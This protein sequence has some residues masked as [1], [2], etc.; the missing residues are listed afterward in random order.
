MKGKEMK[1]FII[2]TLLSFIGGFWIYDKT[3]SDY[4][5][6]ITFLSIMIGFKIASLAILFNSPFKKASFSRPKSIGERKSNL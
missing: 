6:L 5:D 1:L 3:Y 4:T 2:I